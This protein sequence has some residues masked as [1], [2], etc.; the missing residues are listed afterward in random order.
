MSP[1]TPITATSVHNIR[2]IRP[3]NSLGSKDVD[4]TRRM[5]AAIL[6]AANRA[7]VQPRA[8][9]CRQQF[10]SQ[11][12][13]TCANP[14]RQF[15][16]HRTATREFAIISKRDCLRKYEL[17]C[18][19]RSNEDVASTDPT[20]P[21]LGGLRSRRALRLYAVCLYRNVTSIH[22]ERRKRNTKWGRILALALNLHETL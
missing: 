20:R 19:S 15:Y 22:L 7:V 13:A 3:F 16:K 12:S 2:S 14:N 10:K 18:G 17:H 21:H 5:I 4:E 6:T 8:W 1:R 11:T 9:T